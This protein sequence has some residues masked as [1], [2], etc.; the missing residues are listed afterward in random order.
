MQSKP[1][2][3]AY[4]AKRRFDRTPE[5]EGSEDDG[6]SGH[7]FVVQKHAASRL[8]FDF[9]L[10]LDGTLKSWAVPKGPSLD[11]GDRRLAVHVE[12]HPLSYGGFEGVIPPNEYG[13]GTVMLWDRGKWEPLEDPKKGYKKGKLKFILHGARLGGY[14][15]L[16]RISAR[17]SADN[18]LLIKGDD[19]AA[20][21]GDGEALVRSEVTSI[22]SGRTMEEIAADE[23]RVWTRDGEAKSKSPSSKRTSQAPKKSRSEP[24]SKKLPMIKPQLATLVETPPVGAEWIHEIKYD[25]YRLLA[26]SD[27]DGVRLMTRRGQNWTDRFPSVARAIEKL[28]LDGIILDGEVCWVDDDGTTDFQSLQN[29]LRQAD[30]SRIVYFAFDLPFDQGADLRKAPL[31]ERKERLAEL[32]GEESEGVVRYGDHVTGSG[33]TFYQ[34]ACRAA[35]EGVIS[36]RSDAVYVSGRSRS[37]LKSKCLDQQ[38]FVIVGF[39]E[40]GGARVGFGAL[41]LA[42]RDPARNELRYCGRVGT[43]FNEDTLVHLSS[44]L[45]K[46]KRKTAPLVEEPARTESRG[47]TWVEPKL[48]AE[49][50]FTG[51]TEGGRLR[52]PA[53]LGLREDKTPREVVREEPETTPKTKSGRSKKSASTTSKKK[54]TQRAPQDRSTPR[55]TNPDR[56]LYPDTELTK[57]EV[58]DYYAGAASLILP[59]LVNRPLTLVRCPAGYNEDCFYQKK[60]VKSMPASIRGPEIEEDGESKTVIAVDDDAGLLALVQLGVLEIHPWGS[61]FDRLEQPDRLI[62]DLDPGD[63][64]A[65]SRVVE[66]GRTVREILRQADLKCWPRVTGGKGLHLVAPLAPEAD[67]ETVKAFAR[68]VARTM[69]RLDRARYVSTV[70][71]AKRRGRVYID[72]LR[73]SRGATAVASYSTRARPGAPVAEPLD[74]DELDAFDPADPITIE[75]A[76]RFRSNRD[77]PWTGFFDTEQRLP[78]FALATE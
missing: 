59:H 45:R 20:N 44:R 48:V 15:S 63:D 53:F 77:H 26:Y 50:R 29:S 70:T 24:R 51:W 21:P 40:P 49:V 3:D 10:E 67:W 19:E 30:R 16:V 14:W 38:E 62:F 39:T 57:A 31:L 34:H 9:R 6:A 71:K 46:M 7:S 68:G 42:V 18:W 4:R 23:D 66:A 75:T 58:A 33:A 22:D 74:W 27:R 37:W 35:L 1:S 2:L 41:A 56:V 78:D 73:N 47:V 13:G 54:R 11:P 28:Q 8:H 65:W 32:L 76:D 36:K 12:D 52:H 55:L 61:S 64:V 72:Y 60:W 17:D 25:G 43:G 5:P 69:E